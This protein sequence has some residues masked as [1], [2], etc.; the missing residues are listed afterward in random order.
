MKSDIV[1]G[2]FPP[3]SRLK[4][5]MLKKR[6]GMGVNVI[7]ES[8]AKLATENLIDSENQRGF[9]VAKISQARL[10]DLTRMRILLETDGIKHSM[11][12]GGIDWE[13][14]L[15]AAYHKLEY[16]EQKMREDETAHCKIWHECDWNFHA[17]LVSAC[18]SH[19]HLLYHK[20][21]FEQ[22]RQYVMSNLKTYGFRGED[23]I[24][25]HE[26][27]LNAAVARD[28]ERCTAALEEHLLYYLTRFLEHDAP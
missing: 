25:E 19:L 28:Y 8:L 16:I 9:R 22:Y 18:G 10:S 3:G 6:Y 27:I 1:M 15:V 26:A 5:D 2:H 21:V 11:E 17:T 14:D 7:R 24:R 20:R 4:I 23:I 12:N 13:S